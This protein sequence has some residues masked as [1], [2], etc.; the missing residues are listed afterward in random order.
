M[1]RTI[2]TAI[3][4]SSLVFAL[5]GVAAA[6]EHH[7]HN[8]RSHHASAHRRAEHAR[9]VSFGVPVAPLGASEAPAALPASGAAGTVTSFTGG[10]LTITLA[11]GTV[12]A[13]K[14]TEATEIRCES[15]MADNDEDRGDF[16]DQDGSSGHSPGGP[17]TGREDGDSHGGPGSGQDQNDND[18]DDN[19]E[20]EDAPPC[21][22]GALVAGAAVRE[23]EL[24]IDSVGAVWEQIEL[25]A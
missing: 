12:I 4:S 10:K 7:H 6:S 22:S 16:D 8:H 11:D 17:P 25:L 21:A 20:H 24:R 3:A 19:D 1:R 14:V 5:T 18:G 9:T 15:A 23:A 13:G 2:L